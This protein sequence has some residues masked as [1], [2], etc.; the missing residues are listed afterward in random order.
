MSSISLNSALSGLRAAQQ[1]LNT[2]SNNISNAQTPGYTRKILP[3]QTQLIAG[4][5][6]GVSPG[7]LMRSVDQSLLRDLAK[8]FSLSQGAGLREAYLNRVQDFHGASDAQRSMSAQIGK[9]ADIFSEL[10][11]SPDSTLLLNNVVSS[12]Q[13]TVQKFNDFSK[14]ID[15]LR[16]QAQA[17][18]ASGVASLNQALEDVFDLNN[19]IA[20]LSANSQSTADLEDMRDQALQRVS[21]YIEIRTFTT[22]DN[23]VQILTKSGASLLDNTVNPLAFA[24]GPLSATNYYPG[25]GASGLFIGSLTG[26]EISQ[27]DMGGKLGELFRLRDETLPVYQAQ[28]DEMAQKLALRFDA[29]GLRLFVDF[30]GSV[31]PHVNPPGA[32]TYAGFAGQI[33]VNP[34]VVDNPLLIRDGTYGGTSL[35]GS[36]EIVRK[37]SEFAFGAFAYQQSTG[38]QDI[39]AGTL[40]TSLGLTQ[41]NRVA[42]DINIADYS[43]DLDAAPNITAPASFTLTIGVTNYN[44]TIS[45]GDTALDLVN[46][47][48]TAVGSTVAS[49]DGAGRLVLDATDDITLADNGIGALGMA[50]LGFDFG[51]YPASDPSF[52]V[53]VGTQVP[54][55]ISIDSADTSVDLLAQLNAIPGLTATLGG[56]GE[57]ILRPTRGGD[58]TLQN[59]NGTPLNALGMTTANVSHPAFRTDNLGPNA[60]ISTGLVAAGTLEEYVRGIV[61]S[62]AEDGAAARSD[63][64]KELNFFNT[65]DTRHKNESGVNIDEE[66][67]ELIRIQTAYT[68]AARMITTTEKLLDELMNTFR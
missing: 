23:R 47:I 41:T 42:G 16:N 20:T 19:N 29:V 15:Q 35:P 1:A 26:A 27:E 13:Q 44:I 39:S 33:R 57:L 5:G 36:N 18:I 43:P 45:P 58:M 31:P 46:T 3:L 52:S 32:V 67:A 50:D 68:A 48:N 8:Q 40:F 64:E 22:P 9:L 38:T 66:V 10:S 25:G 61:T 12:A 59:A 55:T 14:L 53:Q 17:E 11:V 21:S 28:I 34:D 7:A 6:V 63:A 62:Q 4:F 56:S 49:L 2:I 60:D 24:N 30:D 51:V 37:V 65:L 54:I